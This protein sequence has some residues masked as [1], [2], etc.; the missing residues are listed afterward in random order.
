MKPFFSNLLLLLLVLSGTMP[1]AQVFTNYTTASGLP[2]DNVT[3][4]A[5]DTNNVKWFGTQGGIARFNDLTWTTYTIANGLVDNYINCIAVDIHNNVWVGTDVGISKFDGS[6][7]TS[8]TTA[9]GLVNNSVN[10]IAGSPDGSVWIGTNN[11][12]SNFD[13]TTWK[14]YTMTSGLPNNLISYIACDKVGNTWL[15]TF[16]GGLSKFNGTTFSNFTMTDSLVSNNISALAIDHHNKKWIGS[17]EAS[18]EGIS[19]LDSLDHWVA[20]YR[21]M[22]GLLS[23]YVQDI[24][25]N[26]KDIL[27]TTIYDVYKQDGGVAWHYGSAWKTLTT[28]DGLVNKLVKRLAVDKNDYVWITTGSGVSKLYFP[29]AGV[30]GIADQPFRVF[31]N[32]ATTEIHIDGLTSAG[33]LHI[34]NFVGREVSSQNLE[35]GSNTIGLQGFSPGIYLLRYTTGQDNFSGKLVIR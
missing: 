4:V 13:G 11:G 21:S 28:A 8:Y 33:N 35:K 19:L 18:Y 20:N 27:W 12:A 9:N 3:S 25:F 24:S 6:I 29:N 22:D 26:S 1:Q 34:L 16:I 30:V 31:P 17:Y 7:W 10:Y 5:V 15:G 23:P 32:P 2:S 14:N